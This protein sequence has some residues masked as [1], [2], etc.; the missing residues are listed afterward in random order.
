MKYDHNYI[1]YCNQIFYL[2]LTPKGLSPLQYNLTHFAPYEPDYT[3][4]LCDRT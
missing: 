1:Q 4:I 2:T 3:S